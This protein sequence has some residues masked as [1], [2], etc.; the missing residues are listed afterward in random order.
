MNQHAATKILRARTSLLLAHFFW[1]RLALHLKMVEK[2]EIPTLAVDG[3][4]IFYNPDF[5]LGLSDDLV[6]SA[7]IHEIGHC[8]YEHIFRRKGRD[9]K[10]WNE[11]G[12]YVINQMI[13]DAG[14]R[15]GEKWLHNNAY[16]GMYAE[17]IYDILKQ[18]Q[19]QGQGQGQGEA[20]CDIMD[21][22]SSAADTMTHEME[23][24]VA[25]IQAAT[26][27]RRQGK[28]PASMERF[29]EG[30][31]E[32]KVPWREV[33]QRF[34]TTIRRDDYTWTRPSRRYLAMNAYLPSMRSEGMGDMV[35]VIDTSGS[36]D[37]D[38][39]QAFGAEIRAIVNAVRPTQTHVIYC[40]AAVNHVDVFSPDDYLEFKAHGGGGTDFRPPFRYVE[41][42]NIA[43]ECLVYLTDMYG[44]FPQEAD[45]PVLWCATSDV[46]AP[47]G[48][49]VRLDI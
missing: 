19:S 27:A 9:P 3:K 29:V 1:G 43:P 4:H 13:I 34:A 20:L 7:V 22:S 15:I 16:K 44:S 28:L 49:T 23:W 32:N 30:L 38:T 5:I 39:L 35:V 36:I 45:F 24:K 33:L 12:D 18:E 17:Q 10:L 6:K 31:T 2:P 47:F 46:K 11:A 41:E 37:N 26:E 21:D 48:E 14:F 40:D 8:M 25:V 42:H